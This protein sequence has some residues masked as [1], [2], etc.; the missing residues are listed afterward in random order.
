MLYEQTREHPQKLRTSEPLA[1]ISSNSENKMAAA[2]KRRQP[3]V[4]YR[5]LRL[6]SLA[7]LYNTAKKPRTKFFEV[8]RIIE[9]RKLH[10]GIVYNHNVTFDRFRFH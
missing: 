3:S 7:V 4:D 5:N 1:I 10:V 8:D 2:V 9:K 6:L